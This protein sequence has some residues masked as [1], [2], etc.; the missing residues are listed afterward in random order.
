[1]RQN[2]TVA[3]KTH[4]KERCIVTPLERLIYEMSDRISKGVKGD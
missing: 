2:H 3:K 4:F 1:M